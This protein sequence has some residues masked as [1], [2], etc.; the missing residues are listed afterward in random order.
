MQKVRGYKDI[1]TSTKTCLK[2]T[3][4]L[5]ELLTKMSTL[6]HEKVRLVKERITWKTR[7][8]SINARLAEIEVKKKMLRE[9]IFKEDF[10]FP[11]EPGKATGYEEVVLRY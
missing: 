1:N 4:P 9:P 7:I 11:A 2:R 6:E 8:E 5:H 3:R 10:T